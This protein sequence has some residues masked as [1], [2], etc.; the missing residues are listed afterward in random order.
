M[1]KPLLLKILSAICVTCMAFSCVSA[2][3]SASFASAASNPEPTLALGYKNGKLVT[4]QK[5]FTAT[6]H[7][8]GIVTLSLN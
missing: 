7:G 4:A 1:K 8:S 6:A 5:N 3:T 2:L